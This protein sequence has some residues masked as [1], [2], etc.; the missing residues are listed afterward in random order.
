MSESGHPKNHS[1]FWPLALIGVG[2]LWFLGNIGV[3]PPLSI[4]LLTR[5]W[6]L[7]LIFIGLDL[8]LGRRTPVIGAVIG[9]LL[10]LSLVGLIILSPTLGLDARAGALHQQI[11]EPLNGTENASFILDASFEPVAMHKVEDDSLLLDA[12]IDYYDNF[13]YDIS[14]SADKRLSMSQDFNLDIWNWDFSTEVLSW[15]IG[16]NTRIPW[17]IEIKGGSGTLDLD[18]SEMVLGSLVTDIGSGATD[19]TLPAGS[20]PYTVSVNGG[21]GSLNM[22]IPQAGSVEIHLDGG[23]GSLNLDVP[24]DSAVRLEVQDDGSGSLSLPGRFLRVSG[25]PTREEGEWE[26][27]DFDKAQY[28]ILIIIE[29][30]GSGSIHIE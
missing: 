12:Q 26:T 29:N 1:L 13:Q 10:I 18:F 21:S 27:V 2:L 23:S 30:A 11:S 3:I 17:D 24:S 9:V 16:L 4:H 20:E 8:L 22:L 25:S 28:P 14:G 7:L 19:I 5:L 6:P 15:D